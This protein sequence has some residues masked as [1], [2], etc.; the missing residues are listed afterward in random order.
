MIRERAL[1]DDVFETLPSELRKAMSS[2]MLRQFAVDI[3]EIKVEPPPV[4]GEKTVGGRMRLF[5]PI[6]AFNTFSGMG[7]YNSSDIPLYTLDCMRR[8]YQ[9]ALGLSM[10][11]FPIT[12]LGYTIDCADPIQKEFLR[13]NLDPLW[14]NIIRDC[15]KS[16]DFG[17]AGFEKVWIRKVIDIDPGKSARKAYNKDSICL[18]KLKPIHPMTM[19]VR[20]DEKGNFAGINQ[21]QNGSKVILPRNKSMMITNDEEFCNFFGRSRMV[22]MYEAWYWK[23][24]ST[25]LFLRYTERCSIPP[26]KIFYPYGITRV[27]TAQ[28]NNADIATSMGTTISSFGNLAIPSVF[29]EK[30]N[31]KWD[32]QT[33]DQ[34]RLNIKPNDI[35]GFWDMGILRGALIP[36]ENTL[37]AMDP[38]IASEIFL[39]TL[40]SI[41]N[42]IETK[43]NKEIVDPLMSWNFPVERASCRVN[44]DS[45][46]FKKRSEMRKLYSKIIDLTATLTKNQGGYPF[47]V[48]P[49]VEKMLDILDIPKKEASIFIPTRYNMDGSLAKEK[50]APAAGKATGPD[51]GELTPGNISRTG[52]D[53]NPRDQDKADEMNLQ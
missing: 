43:I 29:D 12:Q 41:V 50:A 15:L 23:I 20:V 38:E 1:P 13:F 37:G 31:R 44:V 52:R 9:V 26:Y 14:T 19:S 28:L 45:I 53:G 34:G 10:I 11:K 18:E 40:S 46:D 36:D 8:D 3:T 22:S 47:N 4:M 33:L 21:D 42:E 39:S 32:V 51:K 7:F 2:E 16:I 5:G 6:S 24:I 35:V 27:G 49:D 48:F 25:Q 30:G 17:F